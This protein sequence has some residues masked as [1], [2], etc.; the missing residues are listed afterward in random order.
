MSVA[1]TLEDHPFYERS[2]KERAK[3]PVIVFLLAAMVFSAFAAERLRS[4][5]PDNHF[6]YLADSYLHGTLQMRVEPPHTNDW[7]SYQILTLASGQELR[8]IWWHRGQRKFLDLE[9]N[10]YVI[11]RHDLRGS[12]EERLH[13]VSFPPMPAVLMMPGVAIFGLDFNDVWFTIFFASLNAALMYMLLRKLILGGRTSLYPGDAFWLTAMFAIGSAHLWCSVQGAVWFTALVVGVTFTLLYIHASID[14]KHPFLA[15]LFLACAFAT[16]TPLLFSVVFFAIFFFFPGGKLRGDWGKNFWKDGLLFVAAPLV[17]GVTLLVF[18]YLRFHHFSEFG[19]TYLAN[20]QIDR[21]KEYGLFNVHFLTV[22]FTALLALL[23]KFQPDAPYI[24]I[25]KHGLAIWFTTP[26]LLYLA[27]QREIKT[28]ADRL[29]RR[30]L[31]ATIF[32]IFVPHIFYQNTGWVQFGYRFSMDYIAYLTILLA[33]GRKQLTSL[34]KAAI[35]L[36]IGINA[37]GAV[38]F[39]RMGHFYADWVLEE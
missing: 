14:A 29:W 38:T 1:E 13:F 39:G 19:H 26:A 32:V 37:F 25:S 24:V 22:N 33:V 28:P 35:I 23:P 36:G 4:P 7:A 3:A 30:A 20:G 10:L 21:I 17:V 27:A 8:G 5:S 15:G 31:Q 2:W 11:D 34:F 18:N 12:T 16:R 9:G 6:A